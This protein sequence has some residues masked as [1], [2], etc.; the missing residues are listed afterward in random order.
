MSSDGIF[1]SHNSITSCNRG[2]HDTPSHRHSKTIDSLCPTLFHQF[3]KARLIAMD[4]N[5]SIPP[6]R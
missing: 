1:C 2:T 6:T 4:I 3:N 5:L